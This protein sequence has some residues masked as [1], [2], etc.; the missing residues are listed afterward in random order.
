MQS[1]PESSM[2]PKSI[3]LDEA[4]E[5]FGGD[6]GLLR[7]IVEA[8][9]VETPGLMKTIESSLQGNDEKGVMRAA[10]TIKS[11]FNNLCLHDTAQL[12]REIEDYAKEAKLAEIKERF[13]ALN[14][15]VQWTIR[16]LKAYLAP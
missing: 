8:F 13:E 5:L 10:H 11:N 1:D 7:S 2:H 9:L 4:C 15:R 6:Q 3:N 16:E 14:D 12:C